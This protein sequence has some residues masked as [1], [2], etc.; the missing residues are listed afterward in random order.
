VLRQAIMACRKGGNLSIVGVYGGYI[1]KFPMCAAMNKG[2]TFKMGQQH[3]QKYMPRLLDYIQ[4][5]DIDP[6]YILTHRWPLDRGP[7]GYQMFKHK[8][9]DCQRV[10]FA[11]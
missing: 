8:T 10:V 9:D 2:L 1:D 7:E 5:G 6:S 3:A 4:N 11:P